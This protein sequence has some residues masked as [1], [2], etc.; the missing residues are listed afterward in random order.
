MPRRAV[1]VVIGSVPM[2]AL[3]CVPMYFALVSA[4]VNGSTA[5]R[6][7]L[8][9]ALWLGGAYPLF[10]L[11]RGLSLASQDVVRGLRQSITEGDL[12]R[13]GRARDLEGLRRE[14]AM[15]LHGTVRGLL[16]TTVM[17]LEFA[18]SS[19]DPKKASLALEE[20]R[21]LLDRAGSSPSPFGAGEPATESSSLPA[22]LSELESAWAGLV[23]VRIH[24]DDAGDP[25]ILRSASS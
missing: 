18:I 12:R 10:N 17:R 25:T 20:A 19:R 23:D 1:A 14:I 4:G 24:S 2:L 16:T 5:S 11:A 9:G 7:A 21:S 13:A 3:S 22:Q 6:L 15:H 8:A